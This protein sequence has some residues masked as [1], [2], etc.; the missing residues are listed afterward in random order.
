MIIQEILEELK[1]AKNPVA[2]ALH[3]GNHFKVLVL[4]FNKGMVLKEHKA[5]QTTKLTVLEGQVIYRQPNTEV[6]LAKFHEYN[7][8][9][10][11]THSVEATEDSL[12]LLTQGNND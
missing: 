8:P 1:E 7:I 11:V 12:C 10:D 2:K 6:V 3:K 4:G 9:V 5:H